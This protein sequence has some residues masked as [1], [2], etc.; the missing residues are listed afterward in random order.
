MA[1][2]HQPSCAP[3]SGLVVIATAH[4]PA[5]PVLRSMSIPVSL[6]A[7]SLKATV[8]L[9]FV[10]EP[11]TRLDG[12]AGVPAITVVVAQTSFV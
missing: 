3:G 8:R 1:C 7:L 2:H 11:T 5:T 9:L 6:V 4:V 10:G 12:A